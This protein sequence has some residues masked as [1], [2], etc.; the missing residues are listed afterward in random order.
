MWLM[1]HSVCTLC[2]KERAS[3][4]FIH[5]IKTYSIRT[6]SS[7]RDKGVDTIDEESSRSVCPCVECEGRQVAHAQIY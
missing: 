3:R 1:F 2:L 7:I 6:G 4:I 5:K